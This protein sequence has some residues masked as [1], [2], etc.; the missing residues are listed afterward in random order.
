MKKLAPAA[1]W[2]VFVPA[3]A[4]YAFTA[5]P[6]IAPR[7]SADLASAAL[8]LGV[9]HPP[10]YPLYS[11]LGRLWLALIPFGGAAYRL[12]LLSAA[13]GSAAAALLCRLLMRRLAPGAAALGALCFA[14]AAGP[15]K[16]AELSEMYSLHALF[17]CALLL[18]AEGEDGT[19]ARRAAATGLLF[20]AGLVN[21]QA[22]ILLAPA[23]LWLWRGRLAERASTLA[24]FTAAGLGLEL[25]VLVRL[26]D[27]PLAWRVLTRADYGPF[28]LFKGFSAPLSGAGA[29]RLDW[30][31]LAGLAVVC[32]FAALWPVGLWRARKEPRAVGLA[33]ALAAFGP[34]FFMMTRFDLSS[35]VART[36]LE[37]AYIAPAL[38]ACLLSAEALAG[39]PERAATSAAAAALV[40]TVALNAGAA[41][42]RD[43]FLAYDYVRDLRARLPEHSAAIVKGDTALFGL[44]Y[45][46]CLDPAVTRT[47]RG[48]LDEDNPGWVAASLA[49]EPD[50]PIFAVGMPEAELEALAA[51]AGAALS[52]EGPVVRIVPRGAAPPPAPGWELSV[53]RRSRSFTRRE[54]YARDVILA[55]GFA[56]YLLGGLTERAGGDP[57]LEYVRA[58]A[59]DP[60]DYMIEWQPAKTYNPRRA[61]RR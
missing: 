50:R 45:L 25:F 19:Q 38:V 36:V 6:A 10:G 29:A 40:L 32:P 44:K 2:A 37:P 20:G 1:P 51:P 23:L 58:A 30:A 12:N 53:L 15:W 7:D 5:Y 24:A 35:W 33:L 42:H 55:R 59:V 56:H 43:D 9:A 11:S 34:F 47:L 26:G 8:T 28:E 60:E 31:S 48:T 41:Y 22:L 17:I 18:L 4:V 27:A 39:L 46:N 57:T 14:F 49:R 61:P 3:F 52:V 21:H 16:F 54:S 13:A